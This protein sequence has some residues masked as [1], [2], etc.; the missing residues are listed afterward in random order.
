MDL[1]NFRLFA[2]ASMAY[3]FMLYASSGAGVWYDGHRGLIL[4]GTAGWYLKM[5]EPVASIVIGAQL[6]GVLGVIAFVVAAFSAIGHPMNV[7]PKS[8]HT[9]FAHR[10][11]FEALIALGLLGLAIGILARVTGSWR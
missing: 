2:M 5:P 7:H 4:K 9:S 6:V 8:R 3:S 10:H 11:F 1:G